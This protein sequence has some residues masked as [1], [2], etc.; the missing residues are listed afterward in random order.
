M[1]SA[2]GRA[3]T[4]IGD[5]RNESFV[6]SSLERQGWQVIY[7]AL[8]YNGLTEFI[9]N[10]EDKE[11]TI[12]IGADFESQMDISINL[13]NE[14]TVKIS[15]IETPTSDY[16]LSELIRSHSQKE[17]EMWA[18]LPP[19][20]IVALTSFGRRAGTSTI[21]IN[22][23]HELA[24]LG[25]RP[26]LIDAH[27]RSPFLA[28]QLGLFGINRNPVKIEPGITLF[29]ATSRED[30]CKVEE[31]ISQFDY[32]VID[33]GE[34]FQPSRAIAGFRQ[35]DYIFQWAV[36]HAQ[37]MIV[38]SQVGS[39]KDQALIDRF[40]EFERVAL[41]KN[42]SSFTTFNAMASKRDRERQKGDFERSVGVECRVFS[43]DD[44]AVAKAVNLQT[45]LAN[46]AP[47]SLFRE[48]ISQYA[49]E[50]KRRG[51]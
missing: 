44:R 23:V 30:F 41:R 34:A 10:L 51:G 49:L 13:G 22:V 14:S 27:S 15:L 39:I 2:Q 37:Q 5:V 7:R 46:A 40:R 8:S 24:L 9:N 25:G 16:E 21:A 29:E 33:I 50:V 12:I 45:T 32:I 47:K 6:A 28:D 20:P 18:R 35:E 43:R 42:I 4:A 11:V 38:A 1:D 17:Q 19:I 48:E 31:S 3:I 26:L 36:H